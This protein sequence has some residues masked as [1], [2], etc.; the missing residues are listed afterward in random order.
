MASRFR[1]PL[2]SRADF[3]SARKL[4]SDVL[5]CYTKCHPFWALTSSISPQRY[6]TDHLTNDKA[7]RRKHPL[8]T[9]TNL[10]NTSHP[11]AIVIDALSTSA[12]AA[13]APVI[14][15]DARTPPPPGG[16]PSVRIFNS[17]LKHPATARYRSENTP[18]H[19][20]A[21]CEKKQNK[22]D[23]LRSG[24]YPGLTPTSVMR[25]VGYILRDG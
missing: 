5:S 17:L 11:H 4:F 15:Q 13:G 10:P 1:C 22:T 20:R 14:N 21:R 23:Q 7:K 9:T 2:I 3:R 19:L 18:S 24:S 16:I 6:Q 12:T 8:S 25:G